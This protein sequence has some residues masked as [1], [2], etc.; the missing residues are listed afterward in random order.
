MLMPQANACIVHNFTNCS[1]RLCKHS[2]DSYNQQSS[3][4]HVKHNIIKG[5]KNMR[6]AKFKS[7]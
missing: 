1:A 4:M 2:A 6:G 3:T 7:D 5:H